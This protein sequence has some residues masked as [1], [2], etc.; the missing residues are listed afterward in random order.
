MLPHC[1]DDLSFYILRGVIIAI[2]ALFVS[3]ALMMF[4][5]PVPAIGAGLFEKGRNFAAYFD[6]LF[7]NGHMWSATKTWDPEG[8]VSTLP[9]IAT[10]LFGALT[11]DYLRL[12]THSKTEKSAWMFVVGAGMLLVGAI[13]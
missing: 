3:Y 13:L 4:Y 2:G 10:T 12:S 9:A 5:I 1:F 6:S 11:G 8:I 7:L